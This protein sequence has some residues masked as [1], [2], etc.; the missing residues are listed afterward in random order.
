MN[1]AAISDDNVH[2]PKTSVADAVMECCDQN[3]HHTS[4]AKTVEFSLDKSCAFQEIPARTN[5]PKNP[6]SFSSANSSQAAIQRATLDA[7]FPPAPVPA[8][9]QKKPT[10]LKFRDQNS[11]GPRA[12]LIGK[13][14]LSL[15]KYFF[16]GVR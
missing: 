3:D 14:D 11:F 1:D 4:L 6:F 8:L 16:L 10:V 9:F 15:P 7:K 5:F 12:P 2:L 13:G